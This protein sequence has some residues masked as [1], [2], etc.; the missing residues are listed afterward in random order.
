MV[1]CW[2]AAFGKS[3][4]RHYHDEEWA[5]KMEMIG[6]QPSSTG[7][8]GGK[9]TGQGMSHYIIV[10]GPFQLAYQKLAATGFKLYWNSRLDPAAKS[11]NNSKTKFTCLICGQNVWGKPDTF[12]DCKHCHQ[13]MQDLQK[14]AVVIPQV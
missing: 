13:E 10:G 3:R 14:M 2:Q 5:A 9:R 6:L 11:K 7:E 12:V 8:P 1:H 4:Q